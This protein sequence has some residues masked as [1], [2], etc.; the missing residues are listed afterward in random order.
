MRK[1]WVL[2][3]LVGLTLGSSSLSVPTTT[4]SAQSSG[5]EATLQLEKVRVV[6]LTGCLL[7]DDCFGDNDEPYFPMI[8]FR[9]R[10]LTPNSTEAWLANE[11]YEFTSL[12]E[13]PSE[14][15]G[16]E[17]DIPT[18]AGTALFK[19]V[20]LSTLDSVAEGD[21]PEIIGVAVLGLEH[22]HSIDE[23]RSAINDEIPSIEA[24]LK[25]WVESG[26][27]LDKLLDTLESDGEDGEDS[28]GEENNN[29]CFGLD[30]FLDDLPSGVS[31]ETWHR[32]VAGVVGEL[33]GG[34]LGG[35]TGA[36][37]LDAFLDLYADDF[38]DIHLFAYLTMEKSG[39]LGDLE[40]EC[41]TESGA[42][43]R[44]SLLQEQSFL[45]G[46]DGEEGSPLVF[47]G[48]EGEWHIQASFTTTAEKTPLPN[49]EYE[50][51]HPLLTSHAYL[52]LVSSS[53][54]KN[55]PGLDEK[56]AVDL[57]I[58]QYNPQFLTPWTEGEIREIPT[59]WPN[60]SERAVAV[61]EALACYD[62]VALNETVNDIRRA[63]IIGTMQAKAPFCGRPKFLPGDAFFTAVDG[64][65]IAATHVFTDVRSAVD[66][67]TNNVGE[68]LVDNE[69]TIVSRFPVV[70]TNSHIYACSYGVDALASKGVIHA[71]LQVGESDS[72]S[73][74]DVFATHL[75]AGYDS[76]QACQILELA[77]FI[78]EHTTPGMPLLLLGDF[79]VDGAPEK[80]Q[81]EDSEYHYLLNILSSLG[82]G[83]VLQDIGHHLT[84]GTNHSNDPDKHRVERIDYIFMSRIGLD[85]DPNQVRIID[86]ADPSGEKPTLSDHA[87]VVAAVQLEHDEDK[88][89]ET[90]DIPDLVVEEIVVSPDTAQITIKNEGSG[91][92]LPGN[93]FWVDLYLCPDSPP[94]TVNQIWEDV[95]DAGLVWGIST[96]GLLL[97]PDGELTLNINDPHFDSNKS[98]YP[99]LLPTS[100]QVYV[101][102][103]SSN[104]ATNF[105]G[106]LENHELSGHPYNNIASITLSEPISTARWASISLGNSRHH[107]AE[108]QVISIT[109]PRH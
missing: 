29:N 95:G 44:I 32:L 9:S 62:I 53:G 51:K 21:F 65:D 59:H 1:I 61:G 5:R 60:T 64:P 38:V 82:T 86:F 80:Q 73:Y 75:Q 68:R 76:I 2:L 17:A 94:T 88:S 83:H 77:D 97:P 8:A 3:C 49:F 96:R 98:D 36:L 102:V 81:D 85:V 105:G 101:Q 89:D 79:N 40:L 41:E 74:V 12:D 42:T 22:E 84:T 31:L 28:G 19:D 52:P 57:W 100:C 109:V 4:L 72:P 70:E 37:F 56:A 108:D 93:D 67:F 87:A 11:L 90:D 43:I 26:E 33:L 6:D 18:N 66:V 14:D 27:L 78:Y 69:V 106:V 45:L 35:L 46:Q 91:A 15:E 71:R 58:A 25:A 107:G 92:L 50:S 63:Q 10:L 34:P 13:D 48:D 104:L 7:D 103:D 30:A 55:H 16:N 20:H 47:N 54:P 23:V 24:A 39:T 99:E